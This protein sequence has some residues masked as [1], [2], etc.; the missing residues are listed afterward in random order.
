MVALLVVWVAW[1]VTRVLWGAMAGRVVREVRRWRRVVMAAPVVM[2]AVR[3]G[4]RWGVA[5][6]PGAP[7]ALVVRATQVCRGRPLVTMVGMGLLVVMV[8][9]GVLVAMAVG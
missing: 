2:G 9:L 6:A 4:W 5:V 7:G 3:G 1:V 8:G